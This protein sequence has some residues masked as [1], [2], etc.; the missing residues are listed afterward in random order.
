[1]NKVL[2]FSVLFICFA[3]YS[4]AA[5]YS[6]LESMIN[7]DISLKELSLSTPDELD[8]II[9]SDRYIIIEGSVASITEIERSDNK[10]ILDI[11][12]INGQWIGL[13]KV[14]VYKCIINLTGKEWENRFPKRV[15]REPADDVVL[16]NSHILVI[17][18]AVDYV[19]VDSKIVTVVEAEYIRKLQ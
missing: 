10:L 11:Q 5:D 18:K 15:S 1:M 17:G 2:F 7:M 19:I 12:I 8:S 13:E 14:E 4:L 3:L 16:L 9:N 6:E